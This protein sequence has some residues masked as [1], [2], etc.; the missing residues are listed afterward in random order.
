MSRTSLWQ[1]LRA[2]RAD[3]WKDAILLATFSQI[4]GLAPVW[5]GLIMVFAYGGHPQLI[6]FA[7][8]GE[9]ALYSA[10][11]LAPTIYLIVSE[12][13]TKRFIAQPIYMLIALVAI[14]LSVAG[15]TLVAPAAIGVIPYAGLRVDLV[16]K[17]T[18]GLF[19]IAVVFSLIVTSLDNSRTQPPIADMVREQERDLER[20]FDKL[21]G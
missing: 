4:G 17:A 13:P 20:D 3:H 15:Y 2:T 6:R 1:G 19:A 16:A 5:I 12:R 21:G 8:G 7:R 9:F 11:V 14:L 10:A 18:I